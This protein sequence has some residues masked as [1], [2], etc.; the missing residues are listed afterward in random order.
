MPQAASYSTARRRFF[1]SGGFLLGFAFGGFFDGILLH[2]ILQWHHL[3]LG[4]AGDT[5]RD[6]RVQIL[7]D[8]LFHLFMYAIA[9]VGLWRLWTERN[10]AGVHAEQ[11]LLS[12]AL[13]G[14]GTWHVLDAILS[15]WVL[16]IHRVKMNSPH[17]LLWDLI[18]FFSFGVALIVAALLLLRRGA[19]PSRPRGR[20]ATSIALAFAT[21]IGG[22]LAALPPRD[23]STYVVVMRPG[24]D[25]SDLLDGLASMGGA[26]LWA[27]R[28]GNMW[29]VKLDGIGDGA[30]LY[31][32]GAL[33]VTASP[34]ALGCLAWTRSV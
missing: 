23:V 2:Q 24:T 29:V 25:P 22:Y 9:V 18:W 28:S 1:T 19:A 32:H 4:V 11:H 12:C 6:M 21:L 14:F 20:V 26:F 3:L 33:L 5:F 30:K 31:R 34:A 16:G 17:P 8:G 15:H 13:L 7:A 27:S 10:D